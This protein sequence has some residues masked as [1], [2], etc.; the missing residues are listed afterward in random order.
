MDFC[1]LMLATTHDK[2]MGWNGEQTG[3]T[4]A[5]LL[6]VRTAITSWLVGSLPE[7]AVDFTRGWNAVV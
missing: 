4:V 1:L 2:N 3:G 6:A 5:Y 7:M